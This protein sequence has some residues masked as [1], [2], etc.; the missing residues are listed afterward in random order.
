MNKINKDSENLSIP[1][2]INDNE[3]KNLKCCFKELNLN[4]GKIFS[5]YYKNPFIITIISFVNEDMNV[6]IEPEYYFENKFEIENEKEENINDINQNLY[7]KNDSM[8]CVK[9][10]IKKGENIELY[11]KIPQTF[12]EKKIKIKSIIKFESTSGKKLDLE[13]NITFIKIPISLFLFCKN[14]NLIKEKSNKLNE[15]NTVNQYFKLD[16]NQ[17]FCNEEIYFELINYYFDNNIDFIINVN[18]LENNTS[19][20]PDYSIKK[21]SFKIIIPKYKYESIDNNEIPR[22]NCVFKIQINKYFI[23]NLTIDSLINPNLNIIQMYDYYSKN[24]VEKKSIIYLNENSLNILIEKKKQIELKFILYSTQTQ[25][26]TPFKIIPDFSEQVEISKFEGII[27][28]I[29]NTFSLFLTFKENNILSYSKVNLNIIV[30]NE[31][32]E[33]KIIFKIIDKNFDKDYEHFKI[34]GKNEFSESWNIINNKE[35]IFNFYVT[36][37]NYSNQ[38]SLSFIKNNKIPIDFDFYYIS[39]DVDANIISLKKYDENYKI[40]ID[41]HSFFG[42]KTIEYIPF[43]LKIEKNDVWYPLT[44]LKRDFQN[45]NY[46]YIEK[47]NID[48]AN[49]EIKNFKKYISK[50]KNEINNNEI[51]FEYLAYLMLVLEK[52]KLV[53][54]LYNILSYN[55]RKKLQ[56]FY[57]KYKNSKNKNEKNIYLYNFIYDLKYIFKNKE[58]EIKN[59]NENLIILNITEFQI[60]Q[61][62]LLLEYYSI[63]ENIEI[64]EPKLITNYEKKYKSFN[65][66]KQDE[67]E[68]RY[69]KYLIFGNECK[70]VNINEK[71][72]YK[73]ENNNFFNLKLEND[74]NI[75]ELPEI[76]L[77]D[78]LSLDYIINL[79]NECLIMTRIF[80]IYLQTAIKNNNEKNIENS[81]KIFDILF[82]IYSY[83]NDTDYSIINEK[84]NEFISSFQNMIVKLKDAN[85]DFNINPLLNNITKN[86]NYKNFF[87]KIPEKIESNI[88]KDEWEIKIEKKEFKIDNKKK[89]ALKKFNY[90]NMTSKKINS[91]DIKLDSFKKNQKSSELITKENNNNFINNIEN[92]YEDSFESDEKYEEDDSNKIEIKDDKKFI[93]SNKIINHQQIKKS[94]EEFDKLENKLEKDFKEDFALKYII[95]KMKNS[96]KN[97]EKFQFESKSKIKGYTEIKNLNTDFKIEDIEKLSITSL[98]ENSSFLSS[99][100]ISTVSKINIEN[101][102]YEIKF[103][104]IEANIIIDLARTISYQNRFFNMLMICGLTY[105]L[106]CLNI[107]Y[108][109]NII[110]DSDMKVRIKN[111]EDPHNS[112]FL[113]KLFDCYFIKRNLT[114]LPNCLK[115]FI[116]N[117]KHDESINNV[118]YIFTNGLEEELKKYKAWKRNFFDNEKNS[119]SFI[120]LKSNFLEKDINKEYKN[121]LEKVW[122]DFIKNSQNCLSNV[123]LTTLFTKEIIEKIDILCENLSIVLLRKSEISD[124]DSSEKLNPIFKLDKDISQIL[125]IKYIEILSNLLNN[126]LNKPEYNNLYIR[127]NKMPNIYDKQKDNLEKFKKFCLETKKMIKYDKLN[128]EIL[129]KINNLVKKFK[130]KKKFNFNQMNIIFKPNLPT[131]SILVEEGTHL[132]ITE[133]IKYSINKD[134]NPRLYREIRDGFIKNYGVSIII[135][136]SI[137]CTNELSII[138]L[139]QTINVLFNAILYDNIPCLDVIITRSKEPII[140]CSEKSSNE[141]LADKSQ[142]WPVFF[143]CLEGESSS[144]LASGIKAA[145]DLNRARRNEYTN[146]IFV[147]TDGLYSPSQRDR[148]IEVVNNCSSKNINIFGIGVGIYPIGIEKLFPQVIYSQNPNNLIEGISFFFGDVTNYK[149]SIMNSFI[150][151][152]NIEKINNKCSELTGE[153]KPEPIFTHLK[154][155]LLNIKINLESFPF[156]IEELKKNEDGSNPEGENSGMYEKDYYRG[157]KILFAMFFSCELKSQEDDNSDKEKRI[158]PENII[159]KIN[160]EECISSVLEY[161]GYSIVVVTNYEEAIN[162]LIKQNEEKK[163]IYNSLWVISGQEIRDLPSNNGD[164]NGPYYVEQFVDCAIEFWKNGGSLVL[165][166]ENEPYNFQL[167][168][169][170]KKLVFPNGSKLNFKIIGNHK[171]G[172]ILIAD[173][174][175]TGKKQTFNNK[176]PEQNNIE[177]K[178]ISNNLNQ[179]FEGETVG[180]VEGDTSPFQYFSIDSEGGINSLFYNGE[181]RQDKNDDNLRGEGEGDIFIDC[182]YTKFFFLENKDNKGT[183]RYLQNIGGFIGS[184]ER[185]SLLGK[186]PRLYR[187]NGFTFKLD[188]TKLYKYPI[189]NFDIVYVVDAT[190][191]MMGTI[192]NVKTYCVEIANKLKNKMLLYDFKFGAIFYRDPID[193]P[194]DKNEFYDLNSN[195]IDFQNFVNTIIAEG[196]GDLAEDWVGGYNLVLNKINW[197]EGNK[198]IIHIADAGAH[199]KDYTDDDKYPDEGPKLDEY[200]KEC[201]KNKITIVGFKIGKHPTKT[202]DRCKKLYKDNIEKIRYEIRDYDQ[203]NK[204]PGYFTNL[205]VDTVFKVT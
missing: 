165:M 72:N 77:Y 194:I 20:K 24:Y 172:K 68:N 94:R 160:N 180:Y 171:G 81:K 92:N 65:N 106:N 184:A 138:H 176:I 41:T 75:E 140:L 42:K 127:K 80:P 202:F 164:I 205:V 199:G 174:S 105:A 178:A 156:F 36:P 19:K 90:N 98:I 69:E 193:S 11:L 161:Y 99:K 139:F 146:Y 196:G 6:K 111:I 115:Y 159:K 182:G 151:Q 170:L 67:K 37:F 109:L 189:K 186:H 35:D 26:N 173:D 86:H 158:K 91:I 163:C 185:R 149:N 40:L 126:D 154:N 181:I 15:N 155:E 169:F 168:L 150:I 100:I 120:F 44:K 136:T 198:L 51:T 144:D 7:N 162:E 187:P 13:T 39:K 2:I 96:N 54:I 74:F 143:S 195:I 4:L 134:P 132:D 38:I 14:Y 118:Y 32:M 148:I 18:S 12:D 145:Y 25:F 177:R 87:I 45:F 131:Q 188:K 147:L 197:R 104:K 114:H 128:N 73:K 88:I 191:S 112:L 203:N 46:T 201:L 117:F 101:E 166:G 97:D 153:G 122:E 10:F 9:E 204:L 183:T 61:I 175:G 70:E 82:S 31:K 167:N 93:Y 17:L 76:K 85:I 16:A 121:Y 56:V 62:E 103:N 79:Y 78:K 123:T 59:N 95:D 22:L 83:K 5:K 179:I 60:E 107:P 84:T 28:Y 66:I 29:K 102:Q 50:F 64:E 119:F 137:S 125:T 108:S 142:F 190:S 57:E 157:Q 200:I 141:I 116:D 21:N 130:E 47:M 110:G 58:E 129:H 192:E 49:E 48:D 55:D 52:N 71:P 3:N 53:D 63:K 34:K 152:P 8:L 135:D 124:K 30:G 89:E 133:L 43:C 1:I 113:Q 23:I 33:F 27:K